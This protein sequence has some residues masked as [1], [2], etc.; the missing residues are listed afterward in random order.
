MSKNIFDIPLMDLSRQNALLHEEFMQKT[1]K[2]IAKSHFI[3]GEEVESFESSISHFLNV[4]YAIG[5]ANGTDALVIALEALGIGAGD[6]VIVPNLTYFASAEAVSRVGAQPV[7][8]DVEL[9]TKN[10][11]P[12]KI[13]NAITKKTKAI[14]IVHLYGTPAKMDE[15]LDISKLY[16]LKVI[17]DCAQAIGAKYR[18]HFVGTLG[19][20]GC[21]SFF[22]TK[23]LGAFGDAGMIITN[24]KL[25]YE[26]AS[27]LRAHGSGVYG[28][29]AWENMNNT[30]YPKTN[31]DASFLNSKYNHSIIGFN[32]RLDEIQA[33]ILNVKIKY[34][35]KWNER[36]REIAYRYNIGITNPHIKTPKDTTDSISVYYVYVITVSFNRDLFIQYLDRNGI[37]TGIYFPITLSQQLAYC[38]SNHKRLL[39]SEYISNNS[40]AIPMFPELQNDEIEYIISTINEYDP[41]E[42]SNE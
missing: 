18:N 32:S 26:N 38:D 33:G 36:R 35:E 9:K 12:E 41:G 31:F 25:L 8:I 29:K 19:D 3:L 13:T 17:E 6:E 2:I 40:V 7:F 27:A 4:K 10:I 22:P 20:I 15:I 1:S 23:N 5:V 42:E 11:D 37:K 21:I 24:N 16:S 28:I 39:V 14:I 30:K 34:L